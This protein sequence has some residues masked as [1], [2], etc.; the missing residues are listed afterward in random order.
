MIGLHL[1]VNWFIWAGSLRAGQINMTS[2]GRQGLLSS[3]VRHSCDDGNFW[4]QTG[5]SQPPMCE[6]SQTILSF[7]FPSL[8]TWHAKLP[9]VFFWW[10]SQVFHVRQ[11][12]PGS[13]Q[14]FETQLGK[15]HVSGKLYPLVCVISSSDADFPPRSLE[16]AALA[17]SPVWTSTCFLPRLKLF[18][19]H[20]F[21]H[22]DSP[23]L[24]Y[25]AY[26]FPKFNIYKHI[27]MLWKALGWS[28][29]QLCGYLHV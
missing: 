21:C 2:Q 3:P 22:V 28:L 26:Y 11:Q 17:R 23:S 9:A 27:Y 1:C 10:V 24:G 8:A 20:S 29:A 13:L 7:P 14:T 16:S 6:A 25:F 15:A 12:E 4:S 18:C 5:L 19:V